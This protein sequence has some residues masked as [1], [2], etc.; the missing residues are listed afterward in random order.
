M[1]RKEDSLMKKSIQKLR[2]FYNMKPDAPIF[3]TEFGFYSLER[4]KNEGY[5]T[6]STD[7]NQLFGYDADPRISF[8]EHGWCEAAF[9]PMF[10]EVIIE[11]RGDYEVVQDYA[12]RHVLYFKNRRS[13]FMPEYLKHP[14]TDMKS[15][16][17]NCKWR[18]DPS[19]PE[20]YVNSETKLNS[21]KKKEEEG[22]IVIENMIGGYM[23][24]RSLIGPVDLLYKFYDEPELIT[25]CMETWFKLADAVT[26]VHQQYV[27]IDEVFLA[28][29]ICYNHGPLIS[30]DMIRKFLLPYYQQ[31][32]TN[33]KRRQLDKKR[34]LHIQIDTDGFADPVI[35]VYKEI[36]MNY[37][38][39]FEVAAGCDVVRTAEKYPDL[40][41]RGGFD[42][43]I[44]AAG[45]DAIDREVDR[46][47]PVLKK[48]G[49]YIPSCDHGVPAEVS[50]ENYMHFRKRMLEFA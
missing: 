6:D 47:M 29:D 45:K 4:W 2:N 20:R 23:F 12:G 17:E 31:L 18:L 15:W 14:V 49:G 40:L 22:Y 5:I 46:I 43:R 36:G 25:D 33:I 3:Q 24:L 11:D 13:G 35:D 19:S 8:S 26:A 44:L 34:V 32:I 7:L 41:I 16:Q 9:M 42:K 1:Q 10:D 37:M 48:R 21:V 30:P 50:F 39:P 28:E 27:T 38:S